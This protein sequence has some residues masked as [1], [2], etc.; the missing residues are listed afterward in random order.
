MT[1]VAKA[2]HSPTEVANSV[3]EGEKTR[4]KPLP[5]MRDEKLDTQNGMANRRKVCQLSLV[6]DL[7]PPTLRM[8]AKPM[9][10]LMPTEFSQ[11]AGDGS[12][13]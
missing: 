12:K 10:A 2:A 8:S 4:M 3:A 9:T 5:L 1:K 6:A 13:W 11:M 7:R